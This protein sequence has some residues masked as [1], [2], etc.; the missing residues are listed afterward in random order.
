VSLSAM[1]ITTD[2]FLL[3][4]WALA[5]LCL[6][7]ARRLGPGANRWWWAL[8]L[9]FGLGLLAKYAMPNKNR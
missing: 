7:E 2:P 4:F 1:I 6:V 5:L 8:G 3:F 9:A